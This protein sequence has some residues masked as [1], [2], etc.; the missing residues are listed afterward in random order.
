MRPDN[1]GGKMCRTYDDTTSGVISG[2][3]TLP[4]QGTCT[5]SGMA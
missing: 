3:L 1:K 2:Q 5:P 4:R